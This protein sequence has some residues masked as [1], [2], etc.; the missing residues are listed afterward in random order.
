MPF[1]FVCLSALAPPRFSLLFSLPWWFSLIS[2]VDLSFYLLSYLLIAASR[3]SLSCVSL[4][5]IIFPLSALCSFNI[6][7][8]SLSSSLLSCFWIG[9]VHTCTYVYMYLFLYT[10]VLCR[11]LISI[12]LIH[13]PFPCLGPSWSCFLTP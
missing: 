2:S 9:M 5:Y 11:F 10:C 8:L 12:L 6:A 7:L 4:C 1:Y 13:L 3:L